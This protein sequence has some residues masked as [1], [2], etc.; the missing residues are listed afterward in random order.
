MT[1]VEAASVERFR[2]TDLDLRDPHLFFNF[3]GCQDVTDTLLL[4][5]S[6][7][8]AVQNAIGGDEGGDGFFDSS[9]LIEFLPLDQTAPSNPITIGSAQ[10]STPAETSVCTPIA[11]QAATATLSTDVTCLAP[12]A[13]TLRPYSPAVTNSTPPCFVSST[14]ALTLDMGGVPITL[15]DVQVGA[16]FV[17]NPA[18]SLSNGLVRGFLSETTANAIIFPNAYPVFGGTPLSGALPGGTNNCASHDSRDMKDG[19]LGW[20]FYFNYQAEALQP[21]PEEVFADGFE[22]TP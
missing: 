5:Y 3:I 20:W 7:N 22:G 21:P 14:I 17:G 6:F 16:T 8:S 11:P 15:T 4:G 19:Q 2:L 12:L 1:V 10:C 9:F 18:T 13:N